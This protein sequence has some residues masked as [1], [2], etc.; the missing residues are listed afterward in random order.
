MGVTSNPARTFRLTL[1]LF[2]VGVKLM[3]QSFRRRDPQ[4]DDQ[5]IEH[6]L[7]SWLRERP[8]AEHGDC[9]GRPVDIDTR[10]G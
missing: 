2:D 5:A 6:Q 7:L 3:R 9:Q 4:A 1:D 8:G 10:I